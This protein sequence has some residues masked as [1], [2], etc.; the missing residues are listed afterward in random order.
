MRTPDQFLDTFDKTWNDFSAAW[1]K[2]RAKASE[3]AVHDLRVNTRRLTA[4]LELTRSLSKH[5]EILKLQRRFKKVLK[6]MGPLRDAQVQLKGISKVRQAGP[7]VA[8]HRSLRRRARRE[9]GKISKNLK[10]AAKTR[11]TESVKVVRS[12][13]VRLH[14]KLGSERMNVAVERVLRSRRSEYVK[15]RKQF[16]PSDEETLHDMRIA[17]KK[18]RYIVEAAAPILGEHA[19]QPARKMQELQT[20]LGDA[21]DLEL[22]RTRLEKWAAKRGKK[23]AVAP[24]LDSLQEKQQSLLAKIE[25]TSA[26][27]EGMLRT[28][29]IK[30]ALEKTLAVS[31]E[32]KAIPSSTT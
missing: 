16:K 26:A 12:E 9:T 4:T 5:E 28:E 32:P 7:I 27:L 17:L 3:K 31:E 19:A 25:E 8:F 23:I 21:R 29:S 18:L 24:A 20:L 22:L 10:P 1:K 30:P 15:T 2:A 11:L 14:D 6:A 13:F